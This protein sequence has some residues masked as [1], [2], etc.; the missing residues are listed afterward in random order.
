MEAL[1]LFKKGAQKLTKKGKIYMATLREVKK[2]F[3][4]LSNKE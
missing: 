2:A 1:H 3:F 4:A